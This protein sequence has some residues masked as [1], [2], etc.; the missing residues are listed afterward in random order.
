MYFRGGDTLRLLEKIRKYHDFKKEILK[1]KVVGGSSAG[2][3]FLSKY[4]F[5]SSQGIIYEGLGILPIKSSCH[6]TNDMKEKVKIL[7]QYPGELVLMRER[8]FKTME[9]S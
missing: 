9:K 5:S 7:N 6:Y 4:A 2:V 1:K 3:Y 8:E